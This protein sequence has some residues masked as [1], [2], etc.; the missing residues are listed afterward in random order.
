MSIHVLVTF[1]RAH[2]GGRRATFLQIGDMLVNAS[3][4]PYSELDCSLGKGLE[5][6]ASLRLGT[7][8]E[9]CD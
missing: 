7:G 5:V 9:E 8:G 2:L 1:L 6:T 3:E 4:L